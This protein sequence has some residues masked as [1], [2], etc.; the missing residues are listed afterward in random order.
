MRLANSTGSGNSFL[1]ILFVLTLTF[2]LVSTGIFRTNTTISMAAYTKKSKDSS[3]GSSG[4]NSGGGNNKKGSDDSDGNDRDK[5]SGSEIKGSSG[6]EQQQQQGETGSTI[7]D[8][9][10][11]IG[12]DNNLQ[13]TTGGE[14]GEQGETGPVTPSV[15][16]TTPPATCEQG[17]TAPE[18]SSSTG[19]PPPPGPIDCSTSPSDPSCKT[20]HEPVDCNTNTNDPSCGTQPSIDCKTNPDDPSCITPPPVNCKANPNDASCTTRPIDCTTTPNDPSCKPDCTKNPDDPSCKVDCTANPSDPSCPPTEPCQSAIIG[21]SCPP[22]DCTKNPDDAS[23]PPPPKCKP[24]ET[25]VDGK[26]VVDMPIDNICMNPGMQGK[27]GC[28]T[29]PEGQHLNIFNDCVDNEKPKPVCKS[30]EHLENG[31]CVKNGPGPDEDCLFKPSLPK[32]KATCD[33]NNICKCP[34]GFSNNEDIIVFQTNHVQK[35]SN[36]ILKTKLEHAIQ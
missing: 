16:T 20:T 3:E 7:D 12:T 28:P 10:S 18:C 19:P 2:C 11:N 23:C 32:C 13:S 6:S 17:S 22:V 24:H 21:I 34:E 36:V 33:E 9:S 1:V 29:C 25:I 31:K 8:G 30:D 35:D 27:G 4:G 5:N 15:D 26:C 14:E